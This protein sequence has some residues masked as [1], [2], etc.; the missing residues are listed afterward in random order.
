MV[1]R[2]LI[3]LDIDLIQMGL[4]GEDSWWAQPLGKYQIKSKNY[5]YS[6]T[7]IPIKS[8]ENPVE[9]NKNLFFK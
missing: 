2:D 4:G 5:D 3:N 8:D 1:G 6:F 7:L 9:L